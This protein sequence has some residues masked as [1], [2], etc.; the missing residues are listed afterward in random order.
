MSYTFNTEDLLRRAA[1]IADRI[2]KGAKAAEI[3]VEQPT[4]FDFVINR[5]AANAMGL[6]I[7]RSVILQV[8]EVIE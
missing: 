2:L 7:P 1:A 4:R 3:P 5:N 8:T 6:V